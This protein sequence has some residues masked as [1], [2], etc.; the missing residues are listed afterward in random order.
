MAHAISWF[1]IPATDYERAVSFYSTVLDKEINE[2]EDGQDDTDGRYGIIR[3]DDGEIGGAIAQM[4]EY[5]FDD[6]TSLSYA[7][8]D[9]RGIFVYLAVPDVDTALSEVEPAGGT[10][11]VESHP[12]D[13]GGEYG[14]I[15]DTEGNRIGLMADD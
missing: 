15:E 2:H 9:D 3:T 6:G 13:E 10:V 14:I 12:L 4:D 8:S 5:T 7:P 1:E 11:V